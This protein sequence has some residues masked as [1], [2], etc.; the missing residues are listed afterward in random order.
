MTSAWRSV[1][2]DINKMKIKME[3]ITP[4]I[5]H[6]FIIYEYLLNTKNMY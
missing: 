4:N 6:L 3:K 1:K 2:I 5:D